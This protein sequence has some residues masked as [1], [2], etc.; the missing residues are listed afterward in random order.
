MRIGPGQSLV[1]NLARLIDA[2]PYVIPYLVGAV[3]VSG[4]S[5]RQRLG[6]RWAKTVVIASGS[7]RVAAPT[8]PPPPEQPAG[9]IAGAPMPPGTVPLPPP[10]PEPWAR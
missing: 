7:E 6:D 1:R 2:L 8:V 9:S 4:S 3:V 10:P 5:T